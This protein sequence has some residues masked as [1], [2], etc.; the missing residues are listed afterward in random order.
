MPTS[1]CR[2]FFS[3]EVTAALVEQVVAKLVPDNPSLLSHNDIEAARDK[4]G[5]NLREM[6]FELYDLWE[7]KSKDS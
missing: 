1:A 4:H 6:L 5:E 3:T 7:A 2:C